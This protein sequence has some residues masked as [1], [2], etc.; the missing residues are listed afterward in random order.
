MD[1]YVGKRLDGRYEIQELIG[2]GGMA[3]VYKAYDPIG[4]RIVAIKIMKDEL[5]TN[6][7]F[8]RRFKNES[9]AIAV[10]NHPNIIKVY[11]VSFG[12]LIQYIVM[13]YVDGITLK[14]YIEQQTALKWKE[15]VHFSMQMLRAMQHAHDKGIV[16]RDLKPQ[17]ILLLPDG[18]IKISD[19]GIARFSRSERR[20]MTDKAI[21]SVH[22]VSPEQVRG[23]VTDE[24]TD[25]YSIGVMM[26]EM[27]TGRVPFDA[28]TAV[29]IAIMQ[30]QN[31]PTPLQQVNSSIP[32]GL[33]Q[34]TLKAMQK[35]AASRY[36]SAA[37][38]LNDIEHFRLNPSATFDYDYFVDQSTTAFVPSSKIPQTV[39]GFNPSISIN[40]EDNLEALLDEEEEEEETQKS[41]IVP[42]LAGI[43]AAFIVVLI[44]ILA[45]FWP[46]LF[47]STGDAV[48]C[49]DLRGQNFADAVA[50]YPEYDIK[51]D[52]TEYSTEY[53]S[54]QIIS[55]TPTANKTMKDNRIIRVV[56]SLG[57][58][59]IELSNYANTKLSVVTTQLDNLQIPHTETYEYSD[60]IPDGYVI[61]TDPGAGST[62][63][64]NITVII[65]VSKGAAPKYVKVPNLVG[66]SE[67][68]AKTKAEAEGLT[69]G[70]TVYVSGNNHREVGLVTK[71]SLT[72]NS[73]VNKGSEVILTVCCGVATTVNIDYG[74]LQTNKV[75]IYTGDVLISEV[76]K[77]NT[78]TLLKETFMEKEINKSEVTVSLRDSLEN[79]IADYK[80]NFA[81]GSATLMKSYVSHGSSNISSSSQSADSTS[82]SPNAQSSTVAPSSGQ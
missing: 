37:E 45:I 72:Q 28:D 44:V 8:R 65:Y 17:N 46:R 10:L 50:K 5:L 42:I 3:M 49:P 73:T 56:V 24:K 39:D 31:E 74:T 29:S 58:K 75:K 11:D 7:D 69:V 13:E 23:D 77:T 35:N 68:K 66:W 26:Y 71:Q 41:P 54:G 70:T 47:G 51:Q 53:A 79:P 63:T 78:I 33:E 34:I 19:F 30:M 67:E 52:S 4:D 62:V 57:P 27:L 81:T 48:Y 2:V 25:L 59:S 55:Q 64:S 60:T 76:S 1:K 16:H 40:K 14:E 12:D 6:E 15:A 80:I 9:K 32:L 36:Q 61:R 43:T 82:Q 21:G 22:Y 38:M 18:S 20:T